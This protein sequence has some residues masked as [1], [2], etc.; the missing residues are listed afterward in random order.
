VSSVHLYA[1]NLST[2]NTDAKQPQTTAT[3]T[4]LIKRL[5]LLLACLSNIGGVVAGQ[6]YEERKIGVRDVSFTT[7]PAPQRAHSMRRLADFEW[8]IESQEGF[9]VIA[10]NDTVE[11]GRV[12]FKYNYTGTLTN[13]KNLT[14]SLFQ[15]DCET[16]PDGSLVFY[17]DYGTPGELSLAVDII[18]ETIQNSVHYND[19]NSTTAVISFCTR[20]DYAYAGDS[21][22]FYETNV[23]ITVDLTA[24]FTLDS[25]AAVRNGADKAMETIACDVEIYY[26]YQNFTEVVPAPAYTQG[27]AL[28]VCVKPLENQTS[29]CVFDVDE[30]DVDQDQD[31]D[32]VYD[33]HT[34]PVT[35]KIA[36]PLSNKVCE[37]G[38]CYVKTQLPSKFFSVRNPRNLTLAGIAVMQLCDSRIVTQRLT[39][40][41]TPTASQATG[42]PSVSP[43]RG[44]TANPAVFPS[45]GPSAGPSAVAAT[46]RP[47]EFPS[48]G[49]SD[50]PSAGPSVGPSEV[51]AT[52]RPTAIP[53][54]EPSA[55][56]SEMSATFRPT[57]PLSAGPSV[58]PSELPTREPTKSP[59]HRPTAGPSTSPSGSPSFTPSTSPSESPSSTP[60]ETPFD[61]YCTDPEDAPFGCDFQGQQGQLLCLKTGVTA[62]R[63]ASN[64][65]GSILVEWPEDGEFTIRDVEFCGKCRGD[66]TCPFSYSGCDGEGGT[67]VM[68]CHVN[69]APGSDN[70]VASSSY[71]DGV[72][73]TN[74]HGASGGHSEDFC[75][76]CDA[77]PPN[78]SRSSE[79]GGCN[80]AG[81]SAGPSGQFNNCCDPC[82]SARVPCQYQPCY[83]LASNQAKKQGS[84]EDFGYAIGGDGVSTCS[85]E[86]LCNPALNPE[87]N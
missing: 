64:A 12:L 54:A 73:V 60:T 31:G 51:S 6:K 15:S 17:G 65:T 43:T 86:E 74:G 9:P 36:D 30:M 47:T 33:A 53:S 38:I 72:F 52:V 35:K 13:S 83:C 40:S 80:R 5:F 23:T 10:F 26:C 57:A 85:V 16:P 55:G 67:K 24:I 81:N 7:T 66:L 61:G 82:D 28:E 3:M 58:G 20:I 8:T 45:T 2:L 63:P 25:I 77:W 75:G 49:S 18:Q 29:C 37:D 41:F 71:A 76:C 11:G 22:N 14:I 59:S 62:C 32:G 27:K 50:R 46:D 84:I 21:F 4:L 34:D 68:I 48:T 39:G 1:H 70:C 44:A 69:S 87:G 42:T 79:Q 19:V 56:P 78:M